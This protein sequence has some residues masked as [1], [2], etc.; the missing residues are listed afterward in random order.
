M[1]NTSVGG[2]GVF[3]TLQRMVCVWESV[4]HLHMT[5][6]TDWRALAGDITGTCQVILPSA[7]NFLVLHLL[8]HNIKP[9]R[10]VAAACFVHR[11]R[12]ICRFHTATFHIRN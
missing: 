4:D 7:E 1:N 6:C 12:V 9:A 11:Q 2:L 10:S 8:E 3:S 5:M